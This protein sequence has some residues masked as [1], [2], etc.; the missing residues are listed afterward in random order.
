MTTRKLSSEKLLDFS[1]FKNVTRRR[2]SHILVA[3]LTS[4]FTMSV[5]IILCFNDFE[6]RYY[7]SAGDRISY[8]LRNVNEIM[9]LNLIFM[10]ALAVYFGIVTLGYMM[11]RKSA[12][13]YHALPE[14]RETL[15]FTSIASSLFCVAAAGIVNLVIAAGELAIFGVG[16]PEVYSAFLAYA[17]NN[18]L[19]FLSTY[20]IVVFAGTV[21]GNRIVQFLM[22]V[23]IMLYP[24]ATYMSVLYMRQLYEFYFYAEYFMQIDFVQWLTPFAYVINNYDSYV[25]ISTVVLALVATVLLLFFGLLIYK[26]RA[27][28]NSEKTIVFK[29]LGSVLKYMF[30]FPI[31]VFA[32][33]FFVSISDN[34]AALVFGFISGALLSFMLFNTILEKTPKAM[35]KNFKGLLIFLLA[36]AVFAAV[37]CFD[38]FD[39]DSYIPA[40][41][42][43]SHV[44]IEISNVTFEDNDFDDPEIISALVTMLK[45]Q[46]EANKKNI[47]S[48]LEDYRSDFYVNTVMHTKLGLPVARSYRISKY[49]EGVDEFLKLYA[50]DERMQAAYD[51]HIEKLSS[52]VGED[53][54]AEVTYHNPNY[55]RFDCDFDELMGIYLSEAPQ[56]A[57]YDTLSK[58]TVGYFTVRY[59]RER[60]H[61]TILYDIYREN[62]DEDI[63]NDLPLYE[64]MTKTIAYLDSIEATEDYKYGSRADIM[65]FPEKYTITDAK[66]YDIRESK[67]VARISSEPAFITRLDVYPYK[68]IDSDTAKKLYDEYYLYSADGK[69]SLSS[70]FRAIDKDY[71][72]SI[73]YADGVVDKYYN[74]KTGEYTGYESVAVTVQSDVYDTIIV[75]SKGKTPDYVKA[76]FE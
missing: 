37:V 45:N 76:L 12:H 53:L 31:T 46:R 62:G 69:A 17:V 1:L 23:V 26:K 18:T 8:I 43:I 70:L 44:E 19:V 61:G 22:T 16:Y 40:E 29:K 7:Y 4:F 73:R 25:S 63:F 58:D 14:K 21:S 51:K 6:S 30:M 28:E 32:G 5:P 36:F 47:A 52:F 74:E 9:V 72:V 24:F 27:I 33:M 41:K 38:V 49:T 55:K 59:V 20:A 15:Y 42:N 35:F 60:T 71:V 34:K 64:N 2:L 56:K 65:E 11:K 54:F 68:Q 3:F 66:V 67:S 75:F 57:D 10:Y 50:D 48:P 39:I 13:F